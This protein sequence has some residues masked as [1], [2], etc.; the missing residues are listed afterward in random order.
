MKGSLLILAFSGIAVLSACG[1][2]DVPLD[3]NKNKNFKSQNVGDLASETYD[4][5]GDV[6]KSCPDPKK[7]W[8]DLD[9]ADGQDDALV[10]NGK[11]TAH[12]RL[13]ALNCLSVGAVVNLQKRGPNKQLGP[14]RAHLK[15]IKIEIVGIGDVDATQAKAVGMSLDELKKYLSDK[16]ELIS[17]TSKKSPDGKVSFTYFQLVDDELAQK[18]KANLPKDN[19]DNGPTPVVAVTDMP[20]IKK[21]YSDKIGDRSPFCADKV[22]D[23]DFI[24]SPE[25]QD[26]M[27]F[28][29]K[30][31]A[32][33]LP[34]VINCYRI[35]KI[36]NLQNKT[37]QQM[38]APIRGKLRI[39]AVQILPIEDIHFPIADFLGLKKEEL[40]SYIIQQMQFAETEFDPQGMGS[41]T[42]FEYIPPNPSSEH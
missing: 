5:N 7:L 15:I 30:K 16:Q 33:F 12:V 28:Q 19:K 25:S 9:I 17:K 18:G 42:F 13:D 31:T 36:V 1:P 6:P 29:G 4:K 23:I 14:V 37:A 8:T 40:Q 26:A 32:L 3:S 35:G 20:G 10:F 24:A 22:E 41:L 34:G 11:I 27:I 38:Q 21:Y 39:V 2:R